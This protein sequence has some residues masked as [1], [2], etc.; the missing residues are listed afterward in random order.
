MNVVKIDSG[1]KFN[2]LHIT[3]ARMADLHNALAQNTITQAEAEERQE[4]IQLAMNLL[5]KEWTENELFGLF[6]I[7]RS[8]IAK[9]GR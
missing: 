5:F 6:R 1:G 9:R 8:E 7:V 4:Q 3:S 2:I